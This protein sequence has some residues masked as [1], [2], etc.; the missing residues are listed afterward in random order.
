MKYI[1]NGTIIDLRYNL[2]H[3][4]SNN[5]KFR[6]SQ[7][8]SNILSEMLS[9]PNSVYSNNELENIG[10][11]GRPVSTS[12]LTVAITSIRRKTRKIEGFKL[13]NLPRKGYITSLKGNYSF[14]DSIKPTKN[15][16]YNGEMYN[17]YNTLLTLLWYFHQ[18]LSSNK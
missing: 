17:N 2:I 10:W 9:N 6:L 4:P 8:E 1:I 7:P 18:V 12:N 13:V 11:E 14:I 16:S 15:V 3:E 5:E